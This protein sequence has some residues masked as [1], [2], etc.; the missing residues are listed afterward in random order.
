MPETTRPPAITKRQVL[1]EAAT[2][3][4]G[5]AAAIVAAVK[6]ASMQQIRDYA[7]N[8][9]TDGLRSTGAIAHEVAVHVAWD[10]GVEW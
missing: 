5:A 10:A 6:N 9:Y 8:A 3:D 4:L 1:A 2:I 7:A